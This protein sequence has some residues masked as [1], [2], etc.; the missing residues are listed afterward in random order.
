EPALITALQYKKV[1]ESTKMELKKYDIPHITIAYEDFIG[2]PKQEIQRILKNIGLSESKRIDKYL[3]ENEIYNRNVDSREYFSE[4][5]L[6]EMD[7][8]LKKYMSY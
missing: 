3:K 5:E 6:K 2:S 7:F 8:L 1:R 4:R